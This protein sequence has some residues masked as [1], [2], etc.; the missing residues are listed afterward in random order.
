MNPSVRILICLSLAVS[1]ALGCPLCE[2][3]GGAAVREGI[4]N[5]SFAST[6]AEV[7]LPFPVVGAFLYVLDRFLPE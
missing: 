5:E 2:T 3:D 7:L 1:P 6:L 4:F